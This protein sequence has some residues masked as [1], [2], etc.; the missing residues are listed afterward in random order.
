VPE[1]LRGRFVAVLDLQAD[2]FKV[3]TKEAAF[4]I[5]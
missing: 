5:R 3:A 1:N 4:T 2:P